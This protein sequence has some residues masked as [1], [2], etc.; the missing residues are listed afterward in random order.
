[1]ATLQLCAAPADAQAKWLNWATIKIN[2][3]TNGISVRRSLRKSSL[4]RKCAHHSSS[5]SRGNWKKICT[6]KSTGQSFRRVSSCCCCYSSC[7]LSPPPPS[8]FDDKPWMIF[9]NNVPNWI[10]I[11]WLIDWPHANDWLHPVQL[12]CDRRR[13]EVK[14]TKGTLAGATWV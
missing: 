7:L 12:C 1:M 14:L 3:A 2:M 10:Q 11:S 13:G 4:R 6:E 8:S 5:S 9:F